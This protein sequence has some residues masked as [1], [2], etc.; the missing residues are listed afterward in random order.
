[1]K[2]PIELAVIYTFRFFG[3]ETL[4]KKWETTSPKWAIYTAK[5]NKILAF[6]S[7]ITA[8]SDSLLHFF[9]EQY[10]KFIF[11]LAALNVALTAWANSQE[12][13]FSEVK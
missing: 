1:M 10:T 8:T 7:I 6:A 3:F 2:D 9:P 4:A 12:E 13:K 11:A 5:I